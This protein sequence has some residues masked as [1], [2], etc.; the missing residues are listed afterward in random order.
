MAAALATETR[1]SP[2]P[3]SDLL[4]GSALADQQPGD[5]AGQQAVAIG[6]QPDR[7]HRLVWLDV[8]DEE[9]L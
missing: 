8:F 3:S 9:S 4:C 7:L 1:P 2:A 6:Q 5:A